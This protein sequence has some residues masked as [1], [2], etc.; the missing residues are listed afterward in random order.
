[1]KRKI[2]V[3][4]GTKKKIMKALN[5]TYPTIRSSLEYRSNTE[6]AQK[7]RNYAIQNGGKEYRIN[8]EPQPNR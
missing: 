7:I 1:M 2:E 8:Q 5:C 4:H 3:D 6:K